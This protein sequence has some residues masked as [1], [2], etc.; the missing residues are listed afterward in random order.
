MMNIKF[1]DLRKTKGIEM[2]NP[3]P[4]TGK[5]VGLPQKGEGG[6][7]VC[8]C[9]KCGTTAKHRRGIPCIQQKCPKCGSTMT[10]V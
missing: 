7:D 2:Q 4:G 1:I 3:I 9:P 6:R 10:G 8:K 5:G